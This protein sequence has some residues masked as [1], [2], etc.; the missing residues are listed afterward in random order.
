MPE[1]SIV[2]IVKGRRKQ[3]ANLL[4]SIKASTV[5]PNDVQVVCMDDQDGIAIPDSLNVNIHLINGPHTLPLAAAR[6]MGIAATRTNNV[7]FIDVDCI[8]SPTLFANMLTALQQG[9]IIAAYPLYLPILPDAGNYNELMHLAM[10]HPAREHI[11]V[12]QPV[13][14]LQFWSLIFAIQKQTFEKI[15]GFDESFIGYG[16]EDTD[17]AMTF[18][19]AGVQQIFVRDYVLHQFHE[20]YDPPLN[21]FESIIEN[22][23]RYREKWGVL[24]MQRWLRAFEKIG[25]I[26]ID[27][28]GPII[29]LKKPTDSEIMCSVSRHPY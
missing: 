24:P 1:F 18:H 26:K 3:L 22:A 25:L 20:K 23:M 16:A 15:G 19:Q 6:N 11:P 2:T 10:P 29:V 12:G 8:V 17:F 27:E 7:I 4:E 5:L 14:H 21:H 28:G 13:E 9:N